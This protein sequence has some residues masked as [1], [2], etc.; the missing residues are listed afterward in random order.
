[1]HFW[2]SWHQPTEDYRPLRYP[3]NE[4]VLGWWCSGQADQGA[5]LC[6]M[7]EAENANR[8]EAVVLADWP[9]AEGWRFCEPKTDL[10]LSD[11]FPL[12]DWMEPR[13]EAAKSK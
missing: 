8:A 9:E 5:T 11:R 4:A 10:T 7:V 1:M 12:S 3:P 6:A 2:I 13:F